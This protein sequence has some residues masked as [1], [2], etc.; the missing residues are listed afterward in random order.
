MCSSDLQAP[1]RLGFIQGFLDCQRKSGK[2]AVKF[3]RTEEWYVS[4]ISD[5]FGLTEDDEMINH[6]RENRKIADVLNLFRDRLAPI[7]K[8]PSAKPPK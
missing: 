7:P 6:K 3:S 8:K 4:K 5:W 1:G 2:E